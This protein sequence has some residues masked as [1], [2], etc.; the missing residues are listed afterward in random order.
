MSTRHLLL[1]ALLA[2]PLSGCAWKGER[3]RPWH[4]GLPGFGGVAGKD[5][6]LMDVVLLEAPYG[7]RYVDK[8]LWDLVDEQIIPLE[9][10][11]LLEQNGFR[12]GLVGASPPSELLMLLTSP[13]SNVNPRR[14]QIRSGKTAPPLVLGPIREQSVFAIQRGKEKESIKLDRTE[15][16][17]EVTA[18]L[19][20]DGRTRL[21]FKPQVKH[22]ETSMEM[23]RARPDRSD[24]MLQSSRPTKSWSS[25]EW[26]LT[27]A[28]DEY[29]VIGGR[30]DR[31]G[32]L[33]H[34]SFLRRAESAPTQRLL[35]IRT[36]RPKKVESEEVSKTNAPPLALQ[37]N[38]SA[39][40]GASV[41]R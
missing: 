15:H 7:D 36:S 41:G 34:T 4:A 2:V 20:E 28:P 22:G 6:V 25:L 18:T 12:I 23:W 38:W 11:S 5:V 26:E 30:F 16:L 21:V 17:L 24:W 3:A 27:L 8:G 35:V 29:V 39:L 19:T 40:R 32:T 13:R 9:K 10:K 37:T 31:P 1:I 33:G 14:L